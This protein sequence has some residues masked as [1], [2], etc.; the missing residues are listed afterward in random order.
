MSS[1]PT[2]YLRGRPEVPEPPSIAARRRNSAATSVQ[3]VPKQYA[4]FIPQTPSPQ[5]TFASAKSTDYFRNVHGAPPGNG[6]TSPYALSNLN[7]TNQQQA[8]RYGQPPTPSVHQHVP[9]WNRDRQGSVSD[10]GGSENNHGA[11]DDPL[12]ILDTLPIQNLRL[13]SNA[14]LSDSKCGTLKRPNAPVDDRRTNTWPAEVV[15]NANTSTGGIAS[16]RLASAAT[17]GHESSTN[18]SRPVQRLRTVE[19]ETTARRPPEHSKLPHSTHH[20]N[21]A[22][23][24]DCFI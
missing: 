24:A 16:R 15:L 22:T 19:P 13:G 4:H 17:T 6:T 20:L 14:P 2:S 8:R 9:A 7:S 1:R 23:P 11:E 5:H 10:Y 12:N 21:H 3:L 18:S